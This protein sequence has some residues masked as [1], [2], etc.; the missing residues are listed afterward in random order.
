MR[1]ELPQRFAVISDIHGN[2]DALKAVLADIDRQGIDMIFN[3]GDHLSGPLAAKETA[4]I[5]RAR[6]MVNLRGN[7]DRYLIEK[8]PS[9]MGASDR[10]AFDELDED[11]LD[12][13]RSLN[14][15]HSIGE[16]IYFCHA[17]PQRDDVYW[18]EKV[19]PSGDVATKNYDEIAADMAS[20]KAPLIFCGHTHL[21]R[22]VTLPSGQTIINPGSV[23]LPSYFNTHPVMH[24]VA[25]QNCFASY[26]VVERVGENWQPNI[27]FIPYDRTRMIARAKAHGRKDW[28]ASL[29]KG[30]VPKALQA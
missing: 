30:T 4:E 29:E 24:V 26:A 11:D 20:I 14:F 7:H 23:G 2:A 21:P 10:V 8:H 17:T 28:V 16:E 18:L 27:R 6:P 12:W 15:D 25:A 1:D 13:L 22:I 3:L 5:I 9:D 19:L